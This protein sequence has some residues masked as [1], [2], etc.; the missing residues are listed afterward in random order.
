MYD[1]NGVHLNIGSAVTGAEVFLKALSI[2]RN[3]GAMTKYITTA[4]FDIIPLGDYRVNI[5]QDKY[6]YYYRPRKNIINRPV[7]MGGVGLYIYGNHE[8]T[9]PSLYARLR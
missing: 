4:N 8:S 7:S 6:E 2:A 9:I 1:E 3:Q 5:G